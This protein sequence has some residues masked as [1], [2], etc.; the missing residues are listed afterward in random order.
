MTE[1]KENPNIAKIEHD[2]LSVKTV[3]IAVIGGILLIAVALG[4]GMIMH[5]RSLIRQYTL[6]AFDVATYARMAVVHG[7]NDTAPVA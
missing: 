2:S 6:H 4:I 7:Q 5:L 3:R 1:V